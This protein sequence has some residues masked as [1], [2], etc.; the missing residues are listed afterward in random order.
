MVKV[1]WTWL[2]VAGLVSLVAV[3]ACSASS[4]DV[5]D[6]G[7][8]TT[9]TGTSQG[10]AASSGGPATGTGEG[11][12]LAVTV[13]PGS[14]GS[15]GV[16]MNPCG[17]ECGPEELCDG[18]HA[19]LDDDCDGVVDETC[20]CSAGSSQSC[21]K[22]DHSFR[23]DPGC[24]PG[25]QSCSELGTW[26]GCTGGVHATD[27]CSMGGQ[28][29]CSPIQTAPF[30]TA[31]LSNGVGSYGND[32]V[33]ETWQVACP[34]GVNPCPSAAGDMFTPQQSGEYTVTYT[35]TLANQ[36]TEQCTY[37]LFV[38][39][40]GLRVELTWE[41]DESLG[42][43]TVDL[44]LHLHRPN[45]TSPWGGDQGSAADCAYDNCTASDFVGNSSNINWFAPNGMPPTP[46]NWY[47]SPVMEENLC[48]YAPKGAGATWQTGSQG[49][50]NPRLDS[51][52]V[53]CDP[54][55]TDPSNFSFCNPEN[56]NVDYPP[57]SEWFRLGV[58][59]YYAQEQQYDVHPVVRI[60]CNGELK[61]ELGP[62][63]YA[64]PVTF[65]PAMGDDA[66]GGSNAFWLVGDVLFP[67]AD[68]CNPTPSCVV[69]P[70]YFD[71]NQ[72]PYIQTT[73]TVQ[74][75]F[76]PAYPPVPMP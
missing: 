38:G 36:S 35:K 76:G 19:G 72:N 51:D 34:S 26:G 49:C 17:T 6:D 27:M 8:G 40:P 29:D 4:N 12:G 15:G 25:T 64:S 33:S 42:P 11:G 71:Q 31:S 69:E 14:G 75:T 50:H 20:P 67:P 16:F 73:T 66:F 37:P 74:G 63:G 24:F 5:E 43:S 7:S 3:N 39:A 45:D 58:H 1:R 55:V 62:S 2:L 47:L 10:G 23:N 57:G 61:A 22:G 28:S 48:F 44:D 18:I 32:A 68:E 53:T 13:G 21:F 30:V 54:T 59:Y 65:T 56:T 70:L 60:F 9:T 52:N 46:V 41:W